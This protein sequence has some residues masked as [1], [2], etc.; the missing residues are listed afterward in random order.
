M[1]GN[2]QFYAKKATEKAIED[3]SMS[4]AI[5]PEQPVVWVLRGLAKRRVG[6]FMGA[7]G[8]LKQ[9]AYARNNL[10]QIAEVR[11]TMIRWNCDD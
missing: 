1:H 8:D 9:G 3:Y 10:P 4:L 2:E 5:N 11:K 6:D 7:C